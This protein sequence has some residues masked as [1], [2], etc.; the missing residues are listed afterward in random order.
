MGLAHSRDH[1]QASSGYV[2]GV[3]LVRHTR[4]FDRGLQHHRVHEHFT[5]R[6]GT[7]PCASGLPGDQVLRPGPFPVFGRPAGASHILFGLSRFLALG[8]GLHYF[9]LPI[10]L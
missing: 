1:R 3:S 4:T 10:R 2:S 6:G 7:P 9:N 5:V 8:L